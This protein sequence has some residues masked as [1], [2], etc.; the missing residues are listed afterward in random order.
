MLVEDEPPKATRG[1]DWV[2]GKRE[3]AAFLVKSK[4]H[5]AFKNGEMGVS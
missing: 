4:I 1:Y 2:T 5:R 3:N